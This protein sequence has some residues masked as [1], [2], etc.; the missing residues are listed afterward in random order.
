MRNPKL[1]LV[2]KFGSHSKNVSV[3]PLCNP[4][5]IQL[6]VQA[7]L[8]YRNVFMYENHVLNI[9]FMDPINTNNYI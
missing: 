4:W 8:Q 5:S 9:N 1:V 2:L 6:Y 3:G 7:I